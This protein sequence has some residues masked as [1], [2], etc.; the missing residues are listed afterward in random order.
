VLWL[1]EAVVVS[2]REALGVRERLLELGGELVEA[3]C[4]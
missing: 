4:R 2:E 3:H 1:D